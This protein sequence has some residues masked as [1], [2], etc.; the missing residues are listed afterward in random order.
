MFLSNLILAGSILIGMV[1]GEP[2]TR[3]ELVTENFIIT[4][5]ENEDIGEVV[6][7]ELVTQTGEGIY[8]MYDELGIKDLKVG[9]EIEVSWTKENYENEFWVVY[10]AE[11]VD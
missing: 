7:G 3:P 11:K 10:D 1:D 8:Y 6:R 5:I 2:V 4:S 9:D